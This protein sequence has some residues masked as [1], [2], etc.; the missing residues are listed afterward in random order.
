MVLRAAVGDF[1]DAQIY[2]TLQMSHDSSLRDKKYF[3][4]PDIRS[5]AL[6][7]LEIVGKMCE[8]R[9]QNRYVNYNTEHVPMKLN[10]QN[11]ISDEDD[12]F[13]AQYGYE[14]EDTYRMF[15]AVHPAEAAAESGDSDSG[16]SEEEIVI[17]RPAPAL[18][19]V[20]KEVEDKR[21][22]FQDS[23]RNGLTPLSNGNV[24][25]E[26]GDE[27]DEVAKFINSGGLVSPRHSVGETVMS[28]TGPERV[29]SPVQRKILASKSRR[30]SN[31]S[32]DNV[33]DPSARCLS[34][35]Q[36]IPINR[37]VSPDPMQ[38]EK[39]QELRNETNS[40]TRQG[41]KDRKFSF[42]RKRSEENVFQKP[43]AFVKTTDELEGK[44]KDSNWL[45]KPQSILKSITSN[46]TAVSVFKAKHND[47]D[48]HLDAIEEEDF[49]AG[50]STVNKP[51][52]IQV[53]QVNEKPKAEV[54]DI[55][56][57]QYFTQVNRKAAHKLKKTVS[58]ESRASLWSF[59]ST[60][61]DVDDDDDLDGVLECLPG[62]TQSSDLR[63][64][65]VK[66]SDI[67]AEREKADRQEETKKR[68]SFAEFC[69]N[70]SKFELIDYYELLK[71]KHI[72]LSDV[73]EDKREMLINVVEL[74]REERLRKEG[75]FVPTNVLKNDELYDSSTFP[76]ASNM[77]DQPETPGGKSKLVSFRHGQVHSSPHKVTSQTEKDPRLERARSAPL[78]RPRTPMHKPSVS[79]PEVNPA[80]NDTRTITVAKRNKARAAL[81]KALNNKHQQTFGIQGRDRGREI[82][83][84]GNMQMKY[85]TIRKIN[86]SGDSTDNESKSGD[87][88]LTVLVPT[89]ESF[90]VTNVKPTD[91]KDIKR[92]AS[93]SSNESGSSIV[94]SVRQR[95]A[96]VSLTSGEL[97]SLSSQAE[98]EHFET[99]GHLTDI[100]TVAGSR[101]MH[102]KPIRGPGSKVDS[103]FDSG[104]MSS[105]M[106]DAFMNRAKH[107][108]SYLSYGSKA[109]TWARNYK[110]VD[111]IPNSPCNFTNKFMP[112][113]ENPSMY[114]SKSNQQDNAGF[115][116]SDV[117]SADSGYVAN[118]RG[119]QSREKERMKTKMN[120]A[121]VKGLSPVTRVMSP[122]GRIM[123]PERPM[124]PHYG[125]VSKTQSSRYSY[126]RPVSALS[127]TDRPMSPP[128]RPMSPESRPMSP[129]SRPMSPNVRPTDTNPLKHLSR[130]MS[131]E[132]R[133]FSPTGE[134]RRPRKTEQTFAPGRKLAKPQSPQPQVRAKS[135]PRMSKSEDNAQKHRGRSLSPPSSVKSDTASVA[136]KRYRELVKQGVPMRTSVVDSS[137]TRQTEDNDHKLKEDVDSRPVT[138]DSMVG[139]PLDDQ[140]LFENLEANGFFQSRP[141]SRSPYNKSGS[142]HRTASPN[143]RSTDKIQNRDKRRH[144]RKE[145]PLEE[146]VR[147]KPTGKAPAH[148]S[149]SKNHLA[150]SEEAFLNQPTSEDS[151]T[152]SIKTNKSNVST[153]SG[154]K[155]K[156]MVDAE[157]VIDRIFSQ[158]QPADNDLDVEVEALLGLDKDPFKAVNE[159]Y[160][161]GR[162]PNPSNLDTMPLLNGMGQKHIH[163]CMELASGLHVI[164][165][166]DLLPATQES[167]TILRAKLQQ[168]GQLGNVGNQ[169]NYFGIFYLYTFIT[170]RL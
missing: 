159:L 15:D 3:F 35:Q 79:K 136:S 36:G 30:D 86:A 161:N 149:P 97:S 18:K 38:D 68:F 123:S 130:P 61:D 37:C 128:S 53:K 106:S 75:K 90:S 157:L 120:T 73:P 166:R 118:N 28:R 117:H 64:S 78:K 34:P 85:A 163:G 164:T 74:K 82:A 54:W 7:A 69:K 140:E 122:S 23:A 124:S 170:V 10:L 42:R 154:T 105:E 129:A 81:R 89:S 113:A 141:R 99:D 19:G 145:I 39:L 32:K 114:E 57:E 66:V 103:G 20:K 14:A 65:E 6:I 162:S 49:S 29:K 143:S 142:P 131:P 48:N 31:H 46:D 71:A 60:P 126:A 134:S 155:P 93:F 152:C 109:N 45:S 33:S 77:A 148:R 56:D 167:F 107:F 139:R 100:E 1:E 108:N 96:D 144:R 127:V 22:V 165:V 132:A 47:E 146:I 4:L 24:K 95:K 168:V 55:I 25:T 62:M 115:D 67:L 119:H 101:P 26:G 43:E 133:P 63:K 169:V 150:V 21:P 102:T 94:S 112:P 2:G 51:R 58:S 76:S 9:F 83:S 121:G 40:N 110:M 16:D 125:S 8:K 151:E 59:I 50:Q 12:D 72:T 137:P 91:N 92:Y 153:P 41:K 52:Q 80:F 138:A 104:S 87:D 116:D 70:K 88:V 17:Q 135:V 111:A 98:S 156:V 11:V 44:R 147:E 27:D 84:S 13:G 160:L 158:N 5:F